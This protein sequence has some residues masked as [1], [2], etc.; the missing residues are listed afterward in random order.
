M[1]NTNF[2]SGFVSVIGRPN[3]GKSTLINHIVGEKIS[4]ISRKPQTTRNKILAIYQDE[5]SQIILIDT[6]GVHTPK[7]K[8]GNYMVKAAY[9][10]LADSD[11]IL[12]IVDGN[13]GEAALD[14][15][16]IENL[17]KANLPVIL[18]INKV[19]LMKKEDILALISCFSERFQF[20]TI[21]PISAL[22]GVGLVDLLKEIKKFMPYGPKYFPDDAVT[23]QTERQLVS[24][25]VREKILNYLHQE[26]P[27][28][29]AVMVDSMNQRE[30]GGYHIEVTVVCERSSH[31]MIIIGKKGEM[32]K[33]I[34]TSARR[35]IESM[36]GEK[37]FLDIWVKVKD[38]WRDN[39]AQIK[40]FGYVEE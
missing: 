20:E 21:V 37:C 31:K 16:I 11:L 36:L 17:K 39:E 9:S 29:V 27:H 3:A 8:L 32:L 35:D 38:E 22:K 18:L 24:E 7:N 26:I 10:S 5:E 13:K 28:G 6:P 15:R 19:D 40:N 4:I 33:R 23:D 2:K 1:E 14:D 34:G 12:L 30:S 25:M